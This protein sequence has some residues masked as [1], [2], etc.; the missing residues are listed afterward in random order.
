MGRKFINM[1]M[2]QTAYG[3]WRVDFINESGDFDSLL[4]DN[5]LLAKVFYD[6]LILERNTTEFN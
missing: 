5:D 1:Y 3:Y 4:F 6:E 2:E